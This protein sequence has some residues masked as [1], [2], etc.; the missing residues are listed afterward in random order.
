M[1]RSGLLKLVEGLESPGVEFDVERRKGLAV[2]YSGQ[3]ELAGDRLVA[4]H[5]RGPGVVK[6]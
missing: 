1:L 5:R 2:V 6:K 3:H 4:V